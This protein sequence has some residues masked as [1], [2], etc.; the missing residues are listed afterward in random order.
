MD[1]DRQV[2]KGNH[3]AVQYLVG[4]LPHGLRLQPLSLKVPLHLYPVGCQHIPWQQDTQRLSRC[5]V[6]VEGLGMYTFSY[7]GRAL[8]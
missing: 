3:G 4:L 6:P 1:S 8:G 5:C 7:G 2:S